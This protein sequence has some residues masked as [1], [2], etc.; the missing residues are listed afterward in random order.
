MAEVRVIEKQFP[1][2]D[3]VHGQGFHQAELLRP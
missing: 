3:V 2:H 1:H